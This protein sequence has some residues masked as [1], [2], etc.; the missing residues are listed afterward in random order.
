MVFHWIL[1]DSI[2]PQVSRTLLSILTIFN[3][4][5]IWMVSTRPPTSKSSRPFNTLL[6]TVPKAAS[7]IGIIVTFIFH[8]LSILLLLLL[9][10][11][12]LCSLWIFTPSSADCLNES[13]SLQILQTLLSILADLKNSVFDS[14]FD[15][16]GLCSS[17]DIKSFQS[18][19]QAFG[20]RSKR[21]YYSWYHRHW[22]VPLLFQFSSKV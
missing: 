20:D 12:L 4:A 21:T 3:Y 11:L 15:F 10:L 19:Y 16:D 13:K 22:H 17:E 7:T 8:S 9:L 6:V 5:V 1:N 2:S 18:P 14:S